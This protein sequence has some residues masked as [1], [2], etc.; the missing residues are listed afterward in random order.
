MIKY[1]FLSAPY[2]TS[3]VAK[4]YRV[5]IIT[6]TVYKPRYKPKYKTSRLVTGANSSY[7]YYL[8]YNII[9]CFREMCVRLKII[10][11]R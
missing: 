3:H 2:N 4:L 6:V 1:K 8:L 5:Y 9:L 10:R 7:T 11:T